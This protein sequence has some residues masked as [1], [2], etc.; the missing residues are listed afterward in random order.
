M[1]IEHKYVSQK[2]IHALLI[3]KVGFLDSSQ[4]I[5][6]PKEILPLG[7]DLE[8]ADLKTNEVITGWNESSV[9]HWTEQTK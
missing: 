6:P 9:N 8:L 2:G 7:T 4:K 1:Y 3:V 5:V